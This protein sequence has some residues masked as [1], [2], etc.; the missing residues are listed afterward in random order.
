MLNREGEEKADR[1]LSNNGSKA[2]TFRPVMG[3]TVAEDHNTAFSPDGIAG[4]VAF[5][6]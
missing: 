5:D 6:D 1:R 4:L 2:V 3:V